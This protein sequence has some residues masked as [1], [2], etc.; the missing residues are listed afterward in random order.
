MA[1]VF[2]LDASVIGK[3]RQRPKEFRRNVMAIT[4]LALVPR[5]TNTTEGEYH[6]A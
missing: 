6:D 1:S 4:A 3:A 5:D 2:E